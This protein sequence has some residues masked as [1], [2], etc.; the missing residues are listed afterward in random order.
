MVWESSI[1]GT[2]PQSTRASPPP[3]KTP[4]RRDSCCPPT[5]QPHGLGVSRDILQIASR[6]E[7]QRRPTPTRSSASRLNSRFRTHRACVRGYGG[8]L[9]TPLCSH[10]PKPGTPHRT[11]P[12]RTTESLVSGCR[13][14]ARATIVKPPG[15]SRGRQPREASQGVL[16]TC[17]VDPD[18]HIPTLHLRIGPTPA[19][20][21]PILRSGST[22]P[23][24]L[25][26][27]RFW[28]RRVGF[29]FVGSQTARGKCLSSVSPI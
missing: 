4:A 14:M 29:V 5:H 13:W 1:S 8:R 11:V 10:P 16:G 12:F 27:F 22:T 17:C 25:P 19:C 9:L 7:S 24:P 6:S 20:T 23:P 2:T 15:A 28:Y 26:P 21:R 3:G 18:S